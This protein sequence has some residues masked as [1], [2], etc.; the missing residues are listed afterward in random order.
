MHRKTERR[1]HDGNRLL[2][3]SP[4]L[5]CLDV[6][7]LPAL[8]TLCDFELHCLAFLQALKTARLDRREV[9]KYIFAILTADK[10]IALSVVEPLY[11]SL[12]HILVSFSFLIVTLERVG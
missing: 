3:N 5:E 2:N 11:C 4:G 12:F 7:C 6:L 8:R 1:S 9:H 10:P